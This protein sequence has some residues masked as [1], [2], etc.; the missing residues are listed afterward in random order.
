[1]I[2][3]FKERILGGE[4]RRATAQLGRL[5]FKL[6]EILWLRGRSSVRDVARELDRP[7]AYTTVMTTLDRLYKKGLLDRSMQN[8]A[9]VYRARKT[10]PEWEQERAESIVASFLDGPGES[11]D[12]LLSSF[13]QAVGQRDARL[14]DELERKIRRKRRELFRPRP[15]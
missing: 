9:F 15:S 7:L 10:R 5:E 2:R 13:L 14:L 8:R 3:F 12:L 6:M 4:D 11:R 1:M